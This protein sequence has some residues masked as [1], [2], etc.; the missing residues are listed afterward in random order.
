[1]IEKIPEQY[2]K[3]PA[4]RRSLG[5]GSL[6]RLRSALTAAVVIFSASLSACTTTQSYRLP[7]ITAQPTHQVMEGKFVW[8]D[9]VTE[10]VSAAKGFYGSLFGWQFE[11]QT[12]NE[13]YLIIKNRGTR[14]GGIV[15][16]SDNNAA[17][18]EGSIWIGAISVRDVDRSVAEVLKQ[19][20]SVIEGPLTAGDR[21]RMAVTKDNVD[22]LVV[23][24]LAAGGDP[25]DLSKTP[26]N[27]VWADLLTSNVQSAESFY[28]AVVGY[29]A[30]DHNSASGVLSKIL[31]KDE[32]MRAGIVEVHWEGVA[33]N[34][35]PYVWVSDVSATIKRTHQL[36]GSLLLR[37]EDIAIIKDPVGAVVGIQ[38][39]PGE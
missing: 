38:G 13:N 28:T 34:W 35:L 25:P 24:L 17:E 20:G 27:W 1:M 19:G 18:N 7:A 30:K 21:G 29:E 14:I 10:D 9:L 6:A 36:G 23:L 16:D 31:F 4:L 33:S 3:L 12:Y 2:S 32:T 15:F 8:F 37:Y 39:P 11:T 22:A 26:G 5:K